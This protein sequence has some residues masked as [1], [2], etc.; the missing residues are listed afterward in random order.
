MSTPMVSKI[1]AHTQVKRTRIEYVW[2]IE[3]F[4]FCCKK[5]E[6]LG[7]SNSFQHKKMRPFYFISFLPFSVL[8]ESSYF[9][10]NQEDALRWCLRLYTR[11]VSNELQDYM[12]LFL[13]LVQDRTHSTVRTTAVPDTIRSSSRQPTIVVYTCCL[14]DSQNKK[15]NLIRCQPD[16]REFLEVG[17]RL[18][19][20]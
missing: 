12:G 10:S 2:K 4:S 11:G 7:K 8:V 6:V 15:V 18:V 5:Y 9:S 13:A 3:D 16:G 19:I 1:W 17:D 14:L 20:S